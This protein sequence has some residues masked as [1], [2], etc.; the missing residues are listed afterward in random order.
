MIHHG[1]WDRDVSC[2]GVICDIP[3]NGKI[4]K[5]IAQPTKQGFVYVL[6]R[7]NGKPVWPIPEKPVAK[8]NV[9]GEWYSPTQPIPSAPPPFA[10]QGIRRKPTW[11]TGRR[12]SRR[13]RWRSPAIITWARSTTRRPWSMT[14]SSAR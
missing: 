9:P 5:A 14:R 3:H 8:G 11:W 7:T 10:K 6:D 12:R 2:A 1:I 4:V 13:G